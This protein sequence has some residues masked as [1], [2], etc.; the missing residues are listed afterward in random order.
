MSGEP[1]TGDRIDRLARAIHAEAVEHVPSHVLARL[2]PRPAPMPLRRWRPAPV[3]GWSL[4]SAFA[5]ALVWAVGTQVLVAPEGPP[6]VP[7]PL[8]ADVPADTSVQDPWDDP[9]ITF[10]EDPDLFVWLASEARPLAM[11]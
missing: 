3:L 10:E 5:A 1:D 9:L 4:A 8:L 11:E 2:R 7:T 6:A